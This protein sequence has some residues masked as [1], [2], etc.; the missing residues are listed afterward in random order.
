MIDEASVITKASVIDR[1]ERDYTYLNAAVNGDQRGSL[2][3][4]NVVATT[5]GPT[6]TGTRAC[7]GLQIERHPGV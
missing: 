4:H 2:G 5:A 3:Q 7:Y 1:S 6:R